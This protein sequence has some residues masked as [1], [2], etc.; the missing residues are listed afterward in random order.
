MVITCII[1]TCVL[2][3]AGI[4]NRAGLAR[5]L[6][7][8]PWITSLTRVKQ[9]FP[10]QCGLTGTMLM[11]ML[12]GTAGAGRVV[13]KASIRISDR[14]NRVGN[15]AH[16]HAWHACHI[17]YKAVNNTEIHINRIM[18]YAYNTIWK[19]CRVSVFCFCSA[20]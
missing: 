17:A 15:T 11:L 13:P 6:L 8:G 7:V 4:T 18:Q 1:L 2:I 3:I 10:T 19:I 16:A 14:L 5:L 9:V 20:L 12:V